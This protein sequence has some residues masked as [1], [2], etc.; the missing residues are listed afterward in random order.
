VG[1]KESARNEERYL[2][3]KK[4]RLL[5]VTTIPNQQRDEL[6][7]RS[8]DVAFL[9]RAVDKRRQERIAAVGRL[10]IGGVESRSE[11]ITKGDCKMKRLA[12]AILGLVVAFG[13]IRFYHIY[14]YSSPTPDEAVRNYILRVAIASDSP[15]KVESIMVVSAIA[16]DRWVSQQTL[17]FQAREKAMQNH[18]AGYAIVRK[19]LFGWYVEK[20]QMMGRSPLPDDVMASLD[21]SDGA[22]VIFGQA[23][24][25]RAARVEAIFSDP[26]KGNVTISADIPEG[27][28]VLFGSRYSELI[29]FKILDVN[30]NVLKQSTRDE[31]QNG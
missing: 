28:F 24:L 6:S 23:F 29:T 18:I 16:S 30:G 5:P 3:L 11:E 13:S 8:M 7:F 31:L 19:S 26:N 12:F 10:I 27:N 21:R 17:L 20:L 1:S 2:P 25:A 9:S 4:C 15:Q 14:Q 22:P